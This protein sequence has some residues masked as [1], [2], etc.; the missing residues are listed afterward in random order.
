MVGG[1]ADKRSDVAKMSRDYRLGVSRLRENHLITQTR[2]YR[3]RGTALFIGEATTTT[4]RSKIRI[5][6]F[7][8]QFRRFALVNQECHPLPE[9]DGTLTNLR[10]QLTPRYLIEII[11]REIS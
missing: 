10:L 6:H 1:R 2:G 3:Q 8:N 5:D 4:L 9:V 7:L 11:P